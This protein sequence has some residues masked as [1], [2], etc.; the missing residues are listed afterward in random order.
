MPTV[1]EL[2]ESHRKR[3]RTTNMLVS[4]IEM[5]VSEEWIAENGI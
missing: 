2:P 1:F 4:A 3:M 5:E